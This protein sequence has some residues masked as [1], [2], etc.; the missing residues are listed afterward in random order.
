MG[1]LL[2]KCKLVEQFL[3]VA[4]HFVTEHSAPCI[5][6]KPIHPKSQPVHP[7]SQSPILQISSFSNRAISILLIEQLNSE[8]CQTN[9]IHLGRCM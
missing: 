5:L 7:N 9:P 6:F 1:K 3:Y 8:S 2:H 4:Q